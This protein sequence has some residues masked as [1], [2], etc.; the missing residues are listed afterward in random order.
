M[1]SLKNMQAQ[2]EQQRQLAPLILQQHQLQLSQEQMQQRQMAQDQKDEEIGGKAYND[3]KGDLKQYPALAAQYGMSQRGLAKLNQ[4]MLAHQAAVTKQQ[5]ADLDV[6]AKRLKNQETTH[7]QLS[8]RY[9]ALL[10]QTDEQMAKSWPDAVNQMYKDGL[11]TAA[12]HAQML[13]T[14]KD[15]PGRDTV[16]YLR[17]QNTSV[18]QA[19]KNAQLAASRSTTAKNNQA[20]TKGKTEDA[21]GRLLAAQT[22]AQYTDA[23]TEA[24]KNGTPAGT[25][26]AQEQMFDANGDPIPAQMVGLNRMGMSSKE[27][28]AADEAAL[29]AKEVKV[30]EEQNRQHQLVTEKQGDARNAI[31]KSRA[32][33]ANTRETALGHKELVSRLADQA[34]AES[35]QNGG[36]TIDHVLANVQDTNNY[37]NHPIGTN[38]GEVVAELRKRKDAGLN[39]GAKESKADEAAQK[40]KLLDDAMGP[41]P[42]QTKTTG[43]KP[44]VPPKKEKTPAPAK[45]AAVP[46]DTPPRMKNAAGHVIEYDAQ[47]NAWVDAQTRKPVQ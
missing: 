20:I 16:E 43:A 7:S 5:S 38:R 10:D 42:G 46:A 35:Y 24:Y 23:A 11:H 45:A 32:D 12:E 25:F 40:K 36:S 13:Q 17:N 21:R 9:G 28:E 44:V 19:T 47:Q 2:A 15:F 33:A 27:R 14:H 26:P 41:E 39:T 29:R 8:D 31:A 18:A 34:T 3:A 4:N 22:P 6:E 30:R 37:Q 1:L